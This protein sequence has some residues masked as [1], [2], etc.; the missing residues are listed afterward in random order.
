MIS[1][2]QR[3]AALFAG[4]SISIMAVHAG[5]AYAFLLQGFNLPDKTALT[6]DNTRPP[7]TSFRFGTFDLLII[8]IWA[9]LVAWALH[10]SLKQVDEPLFSATVWLRISYTLCLETALLSSNAIVLL[11]NDAKYL[12]GYGE[13]LFNALVTLFLNKFH[14][15][16]SLVLVIFGCHL[17]VLSYLVFKSDYIPKKFV[18]LLI[19]VSLCYIINN[20]ANLLLPNYEKYKTTIEIF[21]SVPMIVGEMG[22]GLWLLFKGGIEH[23][24]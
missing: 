20:W 10:V 5:F 16:W 13:S 14:Y 9:V 11:L 17:Y 2:S 23:E 12:S 7:L 19:I 18:F 21:L 24:D 1:I 22:F 15:N 4:F 6:T 8:L 3:D